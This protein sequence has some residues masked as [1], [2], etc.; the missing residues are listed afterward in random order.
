ML[1]ARA[2]VADFVPRNRKLYSILSI[3]GPGRVGLDT[4][5]GHTISQY[6]ALRDSV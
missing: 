3:S 6:L 5:R 1:A 2:A 4:N